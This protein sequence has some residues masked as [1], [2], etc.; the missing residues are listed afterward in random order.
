MEENN[1]NSKNNEATV[2]ISNLSFG[3]Q[4][5]YKVSKAPK[6]ITKQTSTTQKLCGLAKF[7]NLAKV[8]APISIPLLRERAFFQKNSLI[9]AC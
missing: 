3:H 8:Y 1:D 2:I 7:R 5:T 6:N 9:S 4:C